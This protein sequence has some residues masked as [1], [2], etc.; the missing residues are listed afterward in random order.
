MAILR[1]VAEAVR[2]R[3]FA[4]LYTTSRRGFSYATYRFVAVRRNLN[5]II[6]RS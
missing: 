4:L 5:L 3:L 2:I 6:R 1:Y